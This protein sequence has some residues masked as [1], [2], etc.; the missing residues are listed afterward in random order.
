MKKLLLIGLLTLTVA[1]QPATSTLAPE[2]T[3][4]AT[5]L[6]PT[7]PVTVTPTL[8]PTPLVTP[9]SVPFFFSEEFD[10]TLDA[11]SSFVTSG[12]TTPNVTVQNSSL[13]I[14]FPEPNTWYYAIHNAHDY[15]NVHVDTKF[16]SSGNEPTSLGLICMYSEDKGWFEYNFSS[17]GTYNVLLGQ[18]LANGIA[19]YTPIVTDTSEYL[20]PGRT[21]YGMGITCE[22]GELW[23][24]INEKLFRKLN[25]SRYELTRGKVGIAAA[26][27][28]N[29]PLTASFEWFKVSEP[30]E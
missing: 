18:W 26:A 19:R 14:N 29:V 20:T 11:W 6:T 22:A 5:H 28:E 12:E 7:A 23:L 13:I 10:S 24:Y 27:F 21:N 17:D 30:S 8:T 2:S 16:D 25:V 4:T 9:T 15:S 1:C 3:L